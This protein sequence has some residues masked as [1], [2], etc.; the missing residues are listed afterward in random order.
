M[1]QVLSPNSMIKRLIAIFLLIVLPLG[2]AV[3]LNFQTYPVTYGISFNQNHA[4]SLGLDWKVTYEE[5]LKDLEPKA[6]RIAAMWSEVEPLPGNYEFDD[7]DWMME[8]AREYES[9]V[10]LVVG[11]K[12]P[13]WP[14]CHVPGWLAKRYATDDA[15]VHLFEYVSTVVER[16]KDHAALEF[17]QVENEPFIRF[18]FGECD[19]YREDLVDREIKLVRS[20]DPERKIIVTDSGEVSTWRIAS[21]SADIFGT[22]LYRIVRTP[23]GTIWHYDWVP[24]VVYRLKA[25]IWGRP[26]RTMIVS[27]LQ[28]EPWFTGAGAEGTSVEEQEQTMN[29]ERLQEHLDYVTHIGVSRAYLW[30]VEWWYWMKT[31]RND[32]RYWDIV[33][34]YTQQ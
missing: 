5:M 27:E 15:E 13:R 4:K 31:E 20:L 28:A 32:A 6:I 18:E 3:W 7:V 8:K 26:A 25:A 17:W 10:T 14:E 12:A 2:V 29:P 16:Y 9:A 24:P 21:R 33:K 1:G 22:T 23:Q 34:T 19:G 30:G 11:Q